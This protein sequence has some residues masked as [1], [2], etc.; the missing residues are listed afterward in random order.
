[1]T[2]EAAYTA[3]FAALAALRDAG[4]VVVAE[5]R[6]RT[7]NDLN[8]AEL[9]ALFLTVGD[10]RVVARHGLPPKR[11]LTADLY[12]YAANPDPEIAA[13]I[14]LN[15]LIDAVEAALAPPAWAEVQTLG[16]AVDHCFVEGTI[17][18]YEAPKGQRA[19]ALVPVHM[20]LP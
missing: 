12:L 16:G 13:G 4:T 18:V 14:Q 15:G 5:R 9:P 17:A 19:A 20:L 10:Q 2:R 7:L 8:S 1:M 3:L 11:T 6:L